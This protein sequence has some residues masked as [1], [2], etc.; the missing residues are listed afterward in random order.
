[1]LDWKDI[2]Q[3]TRDGNYGIDVSWS[4]LQDNIDRYTKHY[5]L[6]LCP[7]FQR[8]HVWTHEQRVA[9]VEAK[10][11]GGIPHQTDIIRFNH[12]GWQ[13]SFDGQMVCVDGL[14]RLT[15]ALMFLRDEVPV[16]GGHVCSKIG[17][18]KVPWD[19]CFRV[20]INN[21]KTREAVLR[22]YIELN[23]GGTPHSPEEIARVRGLLDTEIRVEDLRPA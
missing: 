15:T 10:L 16:F 18:G 5:A 7:D 20:T 2:P 14:Q 9:Y 4:D 6:D 11:R 8:G 1:M 3:L 21:L 22:W 17:N 23:A 12:P 13:G 19:V